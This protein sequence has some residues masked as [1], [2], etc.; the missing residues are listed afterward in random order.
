MQQYKQRSDI[1]DRYKWDLETIYP[2]TEAWEADF[3]K[4]ETMSKGFR[5]Y[6]GT[7][8]Q[9]PESLLEALTA[10][11]QLWLIA[12]K[13]YVYARMHKDEDNTDARYQAMT[14]KIQSLLAKISTELS[15]FVPEILQMPEDVIWGFLSENDALKIYAQYFKVLLREKAHILSES[16]EKIIAQFSEI[17]GAT[18]DI[19]TMINDADMKFG[20]VRVGKE[21]LNS[22]ANV[23]QR[24]ISDEGE[25]VELTHGNYI[26]LMESYDRRVRKSAYE[27]L[28]DAYRR[29]RNTLATAYSYN[30]KTDMVSARVRRYPSSLEAALAADNIPVSVYENLISSVAGKLDVLHRYLDLRRSVLKLDKIY[31]YDVYVPMFKIEEKSITYE[32][33]LEMMKSGLAVL[34]EEY[35]DVVDRGTKERWID[36]YES[37]GKTSGAYSFGCYAGSPFI[38]MNY[39]GRLNDIFTL[40]HEMG[41]SMHSWYTRRSQPFIYGGHSIFTAEVASTVNESLFMHY[42]LENTRDELEKKYL[43]NMY[44]E[45]FR[46]TLFRQTMFAEFEKMTHETMENGGALTADFLSEEYLKLNKKYFGDATVSDDNIALEWS[47]IPHFYRAFYV[48]KYATGF[49]AATAITKRILSGGA[50]ERNAYLDFLA[51]GEMD[52]PIELLKIAGVDM[53][54]PEPVSQAMEAFEQLVNELW[55]LC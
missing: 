55:G 24:S 18:N 45:K 52:D 13:L 3:T 19:F 40:V 8:S 51:S 30:T 10:K 33:A 27:T 54:Q 39:T 26:V 17:T 21:G 2:D 4:A 29:Q 20:M 44:I 12:E 9:N 43:L 50:A 48:Y 34:G 6:A 14:D 15:F 11:D 22:G 37:E 7:L 1:P 47:R 28:Y 25:E 42:L 46:G 35:I 31:M 5:E 16:E 53:S 23:K 38:L 36:V 41:H 49:S 32:K